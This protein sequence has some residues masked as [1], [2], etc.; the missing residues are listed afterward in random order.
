MSV[1]A[2]ID[3]PRL[4]ELLDL[5]HA[6]TLTEQV[7]LL[8][9]RRAELLATM[10]ETRRA[11][12][13]SRWSV[14]REPLERLQATRQSDSDTIEEALNAAGHSFNPEAEA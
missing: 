12:N 6:D 5:E 1:A 4:V 14:M 10:E 13:S 3:Y 8:Q 9:E 7:R 2:A 11:L